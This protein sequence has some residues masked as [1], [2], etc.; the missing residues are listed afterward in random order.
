MRPE[1]LQLIQKAKARE[2]QMIRSMGYNPFQPVLASTANKGSSV[3]TAVSSPSKPTATNVFTNTATV[4]GIVN[5]NTNDLSTCNPSDVLTAWDASDI[6]TEEDSELLDEALALML[7][8]V[9]TENAEVSRVDEESIQ[10]AV[11]TTLKMLTNIQKNKNEQKFRSIRIL[12]NNFQNK[13]C[14]IPGGM[15]LFLAAGFMI[16]KK[17]IDGSNT[18]AYEGYLIHDQS[19][20]HEKML[21]Y[22]IDRLNALN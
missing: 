20:K 4:K 5:T 9:N 7:S 21:A 3:A 1:T 10:I 8:M 13:I 17:P 2:Q 19:E 11:N 22:V 14:I 16:Q 12:N 15:Q 6:K 18:N